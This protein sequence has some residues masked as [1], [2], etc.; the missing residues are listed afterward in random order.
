MS[1]SSGEFTNDHTTMRIVVV[2]GVTA[3]GKTTIGRRLAAALGF[4]FFDADDFHGAAHV[5]KMARGEA[6]TDSDRAD[7]LAR[8]RALLD[9]ALERDE[10]T[11][12]ACSALKARYR[13]QLGLARPGIALI[14]LRA[15]PELIARRV[16]A[17]AGHFVPRALIPS[18][19]DDLEP[20]EGALVLDAN[21][22]IDAIVSAATA[23]LISAGS[24]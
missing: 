9:R 22:P 20:P 5:A 12:L 2:M 17:R 16:A 6:L 21:Q 11:I 4:A 3:S 14:Y 23:A 24:R 10:S 19:F 7:W 15:T 1:T 18:Q 8:L 13:E